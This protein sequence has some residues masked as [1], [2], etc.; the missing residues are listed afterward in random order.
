MFEEHV[1]SFVRR[2]PFVLVAVLA[3]CGAV[4]C[5][6]EKAADPAADTRAEVPALTAFHETIYE[7]WHTAWPNKDVALLRKLAPDVRQGIDEV[8][9]AELPGILRDKAQ[10]WGAAVEELKR[11]GADY[12]SAAAG[13]DDAALLASAEKLH[14]Q[15]EKLVRVIRPPV[16]ELEA[17]HVVLYRLYHHEMP[18]GDLAAVK[19]SALELQEKAAAL[20]LTTLSPRQQPRKERFDAEA[21]KL[22]AAVDALVTTAAG[23]DAKKTTAAVE[24]VHSAY[25]ACAAV[26]E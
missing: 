5:A 7:I 26:F 16:R 10:A 3:L 17:F 24:E 9:K 25:M 11:I 2:A 1:M 20:K 19:K 6:G 22:A 12:Q 23:T 4:A 13:A 21:A 18:A 15:F 14:A 8:A